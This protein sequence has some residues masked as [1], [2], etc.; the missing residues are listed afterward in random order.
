MDLCGFGFCSF[1][2]TTIS[3]STRPRSDVYSVIEPLS[4]ISL[5][6][7]AEVNKPQIQKRYPPRAEVVTKE[8]IDGMLMGLS[9]AF[10]PMAERETVREYESPLCSSES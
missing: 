4:T 10:D 7:K 1:V 8:R 3:L 9:R 6:A 5:R 2:G